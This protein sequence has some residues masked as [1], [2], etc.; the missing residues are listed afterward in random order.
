VITAAHWGVG[1]VSWAHARTI[2]LLYFALCSTLS[3]QTSFP[4]AH[5]A[6]TYGGVSLGVHHGEG[7]IEDDGTGMLGAHGGLVRLEYFPSRRFGFGLT[8]LDATL[9]KDLNLSVVSVLAPSVSLVLHRGLPGVNLV[10]TSVG[11]GS[12]DLEGVSMTVEYLN[13]PLPPL[14]LELQAR[15]G[16]SIGKQ[17]YVDYLAA[18]G[19]CIGL[20]Y[21]WTRNHE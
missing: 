13:A 7:W 4:R 8:L 21:W 11:F 17:G 5:I 15:I 10:R 19:A 12:R 2:V 9:F 16:W 6:L 1:M 14:P 18:I 3:A 20:G